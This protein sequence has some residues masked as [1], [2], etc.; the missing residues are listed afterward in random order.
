MDFH[1]YFYQSSLTALMSVT[2]TD[3]P[4][5]LYVDGERT[6][7]SIWLS[8]TFFSLSTVQSDVVFS[9]PKLLK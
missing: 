2:S 7:E 4:T 6:T 5:C 3:L 1:P 8:Y 9:Q